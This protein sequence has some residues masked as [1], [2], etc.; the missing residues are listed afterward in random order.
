A[1]HG[2]HLADVLGR[3]VAGAGVHVVDNHAINT[4]RRIGAGVVGVARVEAL[5]QLVP[6]PDAGAR[7]AALHGAILVV[8]VVEQPEIDVRVA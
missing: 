8:P 5:G 3:E 1:G 4:H 2:C 7:V 6:L